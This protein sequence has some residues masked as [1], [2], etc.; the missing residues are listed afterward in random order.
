MLVTRRYL[1]LEEYTRLRTHVMAVRP[2]PEKVLFAFLSI[3]LRVTE[4]INQ[5]R[6]GLNTEEHTIAVNRL[7]QNQQTIDLLPVP[8]IYRPVIYTYA[9]RRLYP[10]DY[11]ILPF[12]RWWAWHC[13]KRW[14]KTLA[15]PI[16]WPH[17]LRHTFAVQW[18]K[19]GGDLTT[20]A[21]W[22]GHRDIRSTLRYLQW[23]PEDL[24]REMNR[25]A[26]PALTG[27]PP[28]DNNSN[29]VGLTTE[30]KADLNALI[31]PKEPVPA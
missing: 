27:Q 18:I 6:S 5:L 10:P 19:A 15:L 11:T 2:D 31:Q 23:A 20:L 3:G 14:A 29:N 25:L 17:A 28:H 12:R 24:R 13:C 1:T 16:L 4:A 22:L 8:D 30:D 7:K 9:R 21:R 26:I